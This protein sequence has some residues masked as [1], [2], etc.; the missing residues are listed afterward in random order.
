MKIDIH[1]HILPKTWPNLAERYGYGGFVQ[2][3]HDAD[4]G[5]TARMMKDGK[6][7]RVVEKNCWD[8]ESRIAD[9]EK[10][11]VS[12]QVL[13]TV[14]VMFSYWAKAAD[15][16]DLSRILNDD[17]AGMVN[18]Y[19]SKFV[20]LG[21][22]PMQD[23]LLAAEEIKRCVV[24]LGMSGIQIGS[25]INNWNL[26]APELI[27]VWKTCEDLKCSVFVHPWDMPSLDGRH[28]KYW[29]PW[30]V[31]MPMET[32]TAIC[33]MVMGGVL[34]NFPGLKVCFAHGGGSYPF[35]IGRIEHGYKVR[36]DLCATNCSRSPREFCGKFYT[37]SLVHDS[38]SLRMLLDVIGKDRVMLGTDYPFPLGELEPGS[39]IE[40]MDDLGYLKEKLL[41]ENAME[42]LNVDRSRFEN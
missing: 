34:H 40:S 35:T 11:K 14:P 15:A 7:F 32:T 17:L 22:V 5:E 36:P 12:V 41:Y 33:S 6:L 24:D 25:H 23:P 39:L 18:K 19:P 10:F 30:L 26:D 9:M 3:E 29:M 27:P 13:S 37:D 20:A 28:S 42:F 4:N 31:G 1:T 8:I 21:T 2:L 38:S 16:L